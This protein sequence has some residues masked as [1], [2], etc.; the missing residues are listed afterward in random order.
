[1]LV[2]LIAVTGATLYVAHRRLAE[3]YRQFFAARFADERALLAA[4][5]QSRL[6]GFATRTYSFARLV[7]LQ[8]LLRR[9]NTAR[10][11]HDPTDTAE[12]VAQL[13]QT[14]EDDLREVLDPD[15]AI[16]GE[17][18]AVCLRLLGSDG[19]ALAPPPGLEVGRLSPAGEQRLGGQMTAIFQAPAAQTQPVLGHLAVALARAPERLVEAVFTPVLDD[20]DGRQ[21][22]ALVVGFPSPAGLPRGTA[23]NAAPAA[24]APPS[25][26]WLGGTLYSA[27]IGPELAS[28]V[29]AQLTRLTTGGGVGDGDFDLTGG[30][31]LYRVFYAPVDVHSPF[32]PARQVTLFALT[33]A[34]REE[35]LL[36]WR[37]AADGGLALAVAVVLSGLLAHGL[38]VPIQELVVGTGEVERGNLGVR[39]PIRGRHELARLAESFNAMTAGLALKERYRSVLNLVADKGIAEELIS[40]RVLLGGEQREVSVLFCDI[41]G[42]TALT[43]GMPP[44]E[45]VRMLNEHF[46]PLTAVV[47]EHHGVVDKFVGDLIMAVFGAPKPTG[48]D[49]LAAAQCARGMLAARRALNARSRYRI[50]VGIGLATG[51]ALAGCMGASDRLNYTVVGERV[52]LASRLCSQAGRMEVVI[53][54][55]T[56]ERLGGLAVVEPLTKLKLKGF[57]EPVP[58]YKLLELNPG[59]QAGGLGAP[60]LVTEH[61]TPA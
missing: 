61:G 20:D 7:R 40:G 17:P 13:Y 52:N 19:V 29:A 44:T 22:G 51:P 53:D 32:P 27:S 4:R 15:H 30:P 38:T 8:A 16:P 24:S 33:A 54:Q 43:Q 12:A 26:I 23:D 58:A 28:R 42:F 35:Q 39:V 50:E 55:T 46:T 57:S 45:V 18:L 1:M 41:R 11:A 14:A 56:R 60:T 36:R 37:I 6:H 49:A 59:A 25:G 9:V 3:A 5:Q 31:T 2:V 48:H 21:L 10:E 34:Q 47:Y